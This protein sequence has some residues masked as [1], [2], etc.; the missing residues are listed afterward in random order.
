MLA[1]TPWRAARRGAPWLL[2][3]VACLA[4]CAKSEPPEPPAARAARSLFELAHDTDPSEERLRELFDADA[5]DSPRP[6]LLDALDVLAATAATGTVR[7]TELSGPDEIVADVEAELDGGG[8]AV[9]S[10]QLRHG[11]ADSWRVR[12]FQGPGIEWPAR[13][14]GRDDGL[15][16]RPLLE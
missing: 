11:D 2:A 8:S 16:A 3:A 10:V 12:W 5:L 7:L 9:F 15:S 6:A 14:A 1:L 4:G 13:P